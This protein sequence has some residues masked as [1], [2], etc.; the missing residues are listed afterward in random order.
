MIYRIWSLS[1]FIQFFFFNL[2]HVCP[3]IDEWTRWV[4]SAW[5]IITLQLKI[6]D[7]SRFSIYI[8]QVYMEWSRVNLFKNRIQTNSLNLYDRAHAFVFREYNS[9]NFQIWQLKCQIVVRCF[10]VRAPH[11]AWLNHTC[12][13]HIRI[14][15]VKSAYGAWTHKTTRAPTHNLYTVPHF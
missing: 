6:D 8:K 3:F 9:S 12:I 13:P 11:M 2:I 4:N 1:A 5:I 7:K 14:Y 15:I 10:G